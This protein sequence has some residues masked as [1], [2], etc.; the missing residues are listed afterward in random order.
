MSFDH[1]A[2]FYYAVDHGSGG[3]V[4]VHHNIYIMNNITNAFMDVDYKPY[5]AWDLVH[6]GEELTE[7]FK[8]GRNDYRIGNG[9]IPV[10][11]ENDG[12]IAYQNFKRMKTLVQIRMPYYEFLHLK[13]TEFYQRYDYGFTHSNYEDGQTILNNAQLLSTYAKV[14]GT[15]ENMARQELELHTNLI[16]Q[17]RANIFIAYQYYINKINQ[18]ETKDELDPLMAEISHGMKFGHAYE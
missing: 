4:A 5:H 16:K 12:S 2:S 7:D 6:L 13:C 3:I 11:I 15:T 1:N 14:L 18:L 9:K 10:I 17:T 8:L